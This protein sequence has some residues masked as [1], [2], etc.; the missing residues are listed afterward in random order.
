MAS[1]QSN[2]TGPQIDDVI[3]TCR[4]QAKNSDKSNLDLIRDLGIWVQ[5]ITDNQEQINILCTKP[6]NID[7]LS[8]LLDNKLS[9]SGTNNDKLFTGQIQKNIDCSNNEALTNALIKI[10]AGGRGPGAYAPF[11]VGGVSDSAQDT[12][13]SKAISAGIHSTNNGH[14]FVWYYHNKDNNTEL[15]SITTLGQVFGAVWNDYAEYRICSE[16]EPGRVVCECGDGTLK[17]SS[18][19]LQPG[20]EIISDTFGFAIGK[21]SICDTPIAVAGRVLA[22]PYEKIKKFKPGDAVC[23][24]PNGTVSKM[25]RREIRKY[26]ERIIGTVSEIPSYKTWGEHNIEVNG[27][28]WI[29]IK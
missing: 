3:T 25:T 19:R 8:S 11:F 27:R 28:I 22:Y 9:L 21:T 17:K 2:F 16:S 24:G 5:Q 12:D 29:R 26:P 4:E 7:A 23:A 1:Y 15:A 10:N 18:C 6:E 14:K 20:A 13:T